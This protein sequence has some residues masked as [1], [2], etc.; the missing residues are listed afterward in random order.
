MGFFLRRAEARVKPV[1]ECAFY[2]LMTMLNSYPITTI[3]IVIV[4]MIMIVTPHPAQPRQK[5][6]LFNIVL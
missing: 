6:P 2:P 3:I 5:T 4:V 1:I